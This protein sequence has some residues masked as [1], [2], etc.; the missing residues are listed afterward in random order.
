MMTQTQ[1]QDTLA[2]G[3]KS[4][5]LKCLTLTHPQIDTL[6][7]VND[8]QP[9]TRAGGLFQA[10][11]FSV[12]SPSADG[13][14][15][16]S[17]AITADLVDQRLMVALRSLVGLQPQAQIVFEIVTA[18]EPDSPIFSGTFE[19]AGLTTNTASQCTITATFLAAG[20]DDAFPAGQISPSNAV[21]A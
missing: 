17:I 13:Q 15:P 5:W 18:D 10:F 2:S 6:R 21:A 14:Q 20:L 8:T 7:L 4:P 9:L 3:A 19:F 11:P 1:M 16:P 12:Q